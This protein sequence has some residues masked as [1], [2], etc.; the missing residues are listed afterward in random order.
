M[1][2]TV[3]ED[4]EAPPVWTGKPWG[5]VLNSAQ[6]YSQPQDGGSQVHNTK[7]D[8]N[9]LESLECHDSMI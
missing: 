6:R 8:E 3:D 1:C 2:V 9:A 7:Q 5:D 4:L